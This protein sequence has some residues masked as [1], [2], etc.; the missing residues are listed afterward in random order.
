[1]QSLL[2]NYWASV[3]DPEW[4]VTL[5]TVDAMQPDLTSFSAGEVY[6]V[7]NVPTDLITAQPDMIVEGLT[8]ARVVPRRRYTKMGGFSSIARR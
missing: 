5:W 3:A 1:L 6:S 8:L 2:E 7:M 4:L